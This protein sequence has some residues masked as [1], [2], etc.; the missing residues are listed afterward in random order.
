MNI[1][2]FNIP[3]SNLVPLLTFGIPAVS[4]GI[5][6]WEFPAVSDLG[7]VTPQAWRISRT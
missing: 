6:F 1:Q 4:S 5:H 2:L 7:D 3:L